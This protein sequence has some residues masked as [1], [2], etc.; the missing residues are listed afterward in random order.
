MPIRCSDFSVCQPGVDQDWV[1]GALI[2]NLN[3]DLFLFG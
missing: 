3:L 1:G 2:L